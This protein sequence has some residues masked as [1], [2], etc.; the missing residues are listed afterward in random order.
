MAVLSILKNTDV[1]PAKYIVRAWLIAFVPTL[2]IAAIVGSLFS[3]EKDLMGRDVVPRSVVFL[4]MVAGAPIVETLLMMAVFWILTRATKNPS[5]LIIYSATLWALFHSVFWMPWGLIV[6]W[7]FVVFSAS[8]V[9]W[10]M[11]SVGK[12]FAITVSVH[13]MQNLIPGLLTTIA[14]R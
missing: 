2:F 9:F 10:R 13:A 4:S 1:H 14:M 3:L 11:K 7:P 12:A 8:Y 6:F 5:R